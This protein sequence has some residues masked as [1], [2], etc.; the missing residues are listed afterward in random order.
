[1]QTLKAVFA[2]G[3]KFTSL[4]DVLQRSGLSPSDLKQL[5]RAGAFESLYPGRRKALWEVLSKLNNPP[6]TPLLDLLEKKPVEDVPPMSA[7]EEVVADFRTLG[8]STGAHPMT[9]YRDW[10]R[11][12][13]IKS[14]HDL[15]QSEH[16]KVMSVAGGVIC[17]QRPET[18]KGFVFITLEDETGVA[19]I[20]VNPK[21]F[22]EFRHLIMRTSFMAVKGKLQL[23]EG[24]AN[25]LAE[26]FERLPV[27]PGNPIL[28]TRDFH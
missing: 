23:E 15:S 18:A 3:G 8:L 2:S 28:P 20:I 26:K 21:V 22:T 16:G 1:M 6:A 25:I 4:E 7:L 12:E 11:H 10:A 13:G 24:V 5:A 27:L 9:F 19:N 14:C 17:R